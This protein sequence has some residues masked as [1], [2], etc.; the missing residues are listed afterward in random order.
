MPY[1][2]FFGCRPSRGLRHPKAPRSMCNAKKVNNA[3]VWATDM[4]DVPTASGNLV[5]F[6]KSM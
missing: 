6:D 2:D 4:E 3:T 5:S 1:P